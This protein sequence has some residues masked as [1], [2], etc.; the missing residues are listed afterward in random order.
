VLIY[1]TSI[2]LKLVM[3]RVIESVTRIILLLSFIWLA[4][5]FSCS[6]IDKE[7]ADNTCKVI[8]PIEDLSWLKEEIEIMKDCRFC[9]VK[10]GSLDNETV[11]IVSNCNPLWNSISIISNCSGD[12]IGYGLEVESKIVNQVVVWKH[13]DSECVSVN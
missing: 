11:F 13:M 10:M 5:L 7:L 6:K 2:I 3:M 1:S 12:A 8:S 4:E 9:Y